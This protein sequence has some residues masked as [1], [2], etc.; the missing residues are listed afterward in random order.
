MNLSHETLE[1]LAA[2][3]LEAAGS[4]R[5]EARTVASHLLQANLCG[6]DSHGVGMLPTYVANIAK[7]LLQPNR[8]PET[9]SDRGNF[10]L[11]DG[12]RGYGQVAAKMAME[13]G[14]A[15][16]KETGM[17]LVGLRN[18]HHIGRVGAYGEQSME[19]GLISLHFVSVVGHA[20]MVAPFGGKQGRYGT[21][22]LCIAVPSLNDEDHLLL[23]MAT[24][25]IAVGK[26]RVAL[27]KGQQV[28]DCAL[29]DSQ[30]RPTE[31][32]EVLFTQPQ[33]AIL[34]FGEH[35][36]YG[37]GLLC[38]VL[39]VALTGGASIHPDNAR[40]GGIINH[41]L[42]ILIDP[43]LYGEQN[44]IRRE[45]AALID[46]LRATPPV[47]ADCPVMVPGDPERKRRQERLTS[48]ILIEEVT[49][50]EIVEA[51]LSVGL[52]IKKFTH[53]IC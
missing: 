48:G 29:I 3:I 38:E 40:C 28:S 19:A 13:Q 53:A 4:A 9:I 18:A 33:G 37:L 26:A 16:C 43:E 20:P 31:N 6:H 2:A 10:L 50:D 5:P 42:T 14:I 12:H 35:K 44:A 49:W 34:P 46:Y 24:S 17:A 7:G 1:D 51:A 52:D 25:K 30:G 47:Q 11:F 23:D 32:P 27:N 41:M 8:L 45:I 21:N 39:A 15:R 36:G 22:P